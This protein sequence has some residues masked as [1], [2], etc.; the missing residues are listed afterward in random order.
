MENP[1]KMDDLGVPLFLETAIWRTLLYPLIFI[2]SLGS[3]LRLAGECAVCRWCK[4]IQWTA[5]QTRLQHSGCAQG[6]APLWFIKCHFFSFFFIWI[7]DSWKQENKFCISFLPLSICFRLPCGQFTLPWVLSRD[8]SYFVESVP[9]ATISATSKPMTTFP[10]KVTGLLASLPCKVTNKFPYGPHPRIY[11]YRLHNRI[12]NRSV[13][14]GFVK[15][16][17]AAPIG[18][19]PRFQNNT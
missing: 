8:I 9:L 6:W 14:I 11:R 4:S 2:I 12:A 5:S 10:T 15:P 13:R 16:L 1:I 7:I 19:V 3:C 18:E 17:N